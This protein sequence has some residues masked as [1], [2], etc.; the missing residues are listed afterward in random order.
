[1]GSAAS[2]GGGVEGSQQPHQ[3]TP[4]LALCAD[5]CNGI[6]HFTLGRAASSDT[7]TTISRQDAALALPVFETRTKFPR[8]AERLR[9]RQ[10]AEAHAATAVHRWHITS[11]GQQYDAVQLADEVIVEWER[12]LK[13]NGVL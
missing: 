6:K 9:E 2:S 1:V 8:P 13:S 12:W 7:S 11:N 3:A 10:D 4:A 5:V